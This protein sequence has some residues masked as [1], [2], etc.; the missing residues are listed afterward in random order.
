METILNFF[1]SLF[2]AKFISNLELNANPFFLKRETEKF[3]K[4]LKISELQEKYDRAVCEYDTFVN[5]AYRRMQTSAYGKKESEQIYN[6]ETSLL[7]LE[8]AKLCEKKRKYFDEITN[9]LYN[10]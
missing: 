8:Y 9:V 1:F 3:L 6:I 10:E 7:N 2:F 4:S 5:D